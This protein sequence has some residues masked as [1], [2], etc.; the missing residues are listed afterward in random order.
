MQMNIND[1]LQLDISHRGKKPNIK[2]KFNASQL[3][4]VSII[5]LHL[6]RVRTLQLQLMVRTMTLK[7][8]ITD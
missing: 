6:Q 3:I 7:I 5:Q 2:T 4:I 1:Q 8:N